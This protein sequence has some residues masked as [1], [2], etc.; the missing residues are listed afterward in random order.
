MI[1]KV[2]RKDSWHYK[3]CVWVYDSDD[4]W[5]D[6]YDPTHYCEHIAKTILA[7][8]YVLIAAA[9]LVSLL[10]VLTMAP[11]AV[12][13]LVTD[14]MYITLSCISWV[15][16]IG[17]FVLGWAFKPKRHKVEIMDKICSRVKF[18]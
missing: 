3:L 4:G 15:F 9:L 2:L 11:L 13:G 8:L 10:T 18:E 6:S 17:A 1:T 14:P 7:I 16:M 5:C 12:L